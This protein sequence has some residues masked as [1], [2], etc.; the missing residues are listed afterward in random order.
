MGAVSVR[1]IGLGI[2]LS[3]VSSVAM[4]LVSIVLLMVSGCRVTVALCCAW[5]AG[6]ASVS[7]DLMVAAIVVLSFG[8]E[9]RASYKGETRGE[10]CKHSVK[11]WIKNSV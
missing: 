9:S 7:I 4:H 6:C 5:M 1:M 11:V 8:S 10:I 3:G 2:A